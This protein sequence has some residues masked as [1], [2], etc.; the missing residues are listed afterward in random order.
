MNR[1]HS[2][3]QPRLAVLLTHPIHYLL[4][5]FRYVA[6]QTDID[7]HLYMA[8]AFGFGEQVDP[9]AGVALQWHQDRSILDGLPHTFLTSSSTAPSGFASNLAPRLV[10][11]L[12]QRPADALMIRGYAELNSY[13]GYAAA[14]LTHTPVLFHGET[15]LL[16]RTTGRE[17]IREALVRVIL[18]RSAA[19]L[20]IGSQSI[21]FYRSYGVGDEKLFLAPY[22][23]DNDYFSTEH[24]RLKPY[25]AE[26]RSKYGIE[27][28]LPVILFVGKL[29]PRKRPL[30]LLAAFEPYQHAA[31]L[32]F[33]GDGL[34]RAE[35]AA[36]IAARAIRNVHQPGFLNQTNLPELYTLA[37]IFVCPSEYEP[38]GLVLN[39]A[40][41]SHL[42]VI[43]SDG[44]AA[45]FDLVHN[46]E[47]GFVYPAGHVN[48]LQNRIRTLVE[49]PELRA[50]MGENSA[51]II[52]RWSFAE[53]TRGLADA[54]RSVTTHRA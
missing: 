35:M 45:H 7:V 1:A 39:E 26:L 33:A 25:R 29:I 43:V 51:R 22:S 11:E 36:A 16:N 34:L 13:I 38:W 47:N 53:A 19:F 48:A 9:T 41:C 54:L 6:Q 27:E 28:A 44:V 52:Q 21:A 17:W 50:G 5:W 12:R 10:T 37:D 49:S 2:A 46:G 15:N 32:V 18:A 14:A 8:S 42:P 30:D 40:M 31:H 20:A 4:G 24:C 3:P 23:V